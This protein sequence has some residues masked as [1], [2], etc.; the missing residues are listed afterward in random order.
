MACSNAE[1]PATA[2]TVNGPLKIERFGRRLFEPDTLTI[3]DRQTHHVA[4]RFLMRPELAAA[5]AHLVFGEVRS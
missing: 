4:R 3:A 1:R 2:R 5:V